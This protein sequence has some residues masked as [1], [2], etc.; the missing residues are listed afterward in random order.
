MD[1]LKTL[2]VKT[3]KVSERRIYTGPYKQF[4]RINNVSMCSIYKLELHFF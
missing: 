2:L 4:I 1:L 3:S